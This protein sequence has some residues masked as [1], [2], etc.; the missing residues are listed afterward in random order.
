MAF[1]LVSKFDNLHPS[2][3]SDE[4]ISNESNLRI[5]SFLLQLYLTPVDLASAAVAVLVEVVPWL[6]LGK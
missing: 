1:V 4:A 6:V 2:K 5:C 3:S